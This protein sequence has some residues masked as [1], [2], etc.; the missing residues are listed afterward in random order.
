MTKKRS[1][2]RHPK[3]EVG[4]GLSSRAAGVSVPRNMIA[5]RVRVHVPYHTH[6]R[7]TPGA[8]FGS[9]QFNLESGFDPDRTAAG[10]QP[11]SW[12]VWNN[13]YVRYRVWGV[14]VV[15]FG[16]SANAAGE[17][18]IIALTPVVNDTSV[19][20][21]SA[22]AIENARSMHGVHQV[23]APAIQLVKS[24]NLPEVIGMSTTQFAGDDSYEALFGASPAQTVTLNLFYEH[25]SGGN[26][27]IDFSI[28]L[29]YD[30]EMFE[31]KV[32]PAS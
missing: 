7:R 14:K 28:L 27:V 4:L 1:A 17:S 12:D 25:I 2:R 29:M 10:H 11:M 22:T 6:A 15:L 21:A 19:F 26:V 32:L 20:T 16:T 31:R 3:D 18:V 13:F 8:A 23:G 24:Y 9:Y 30:V 5:D